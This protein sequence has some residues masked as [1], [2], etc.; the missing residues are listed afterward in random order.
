MLFD[1]AT[2][3]IEGVVRYG[4]PSSKA[5]MPSAFYVPANVSLRPAL[6]AV[7]LRLLESG[8]GSFSLSFFNTYDSERFSTYNGDYSAGTLR[9]CE[10]ERCD[11]P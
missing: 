5:R 11:Q 2:A 6:A 4:P 8:G 1:R 9:A 7:A 10:S 3:G